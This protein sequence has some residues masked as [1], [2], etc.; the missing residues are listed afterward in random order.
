MVRVRI[1][2]RV[3]VRV[4]GRV[5]VS[6]LRHDDCRINPDACNTNLDVVG[7]INPDAFNTGKS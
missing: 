2:V 4:S 5:G 1:R 3:S 6:G 7:R